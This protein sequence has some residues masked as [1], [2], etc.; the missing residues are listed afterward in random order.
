MAKLRCCEH[1]IQVGQPQ[2]QGMC[3]D[4]LQR[5][6]LDGGRQLQGTLQQQ[7]SALVKAQLQRRLSLHLSWA[8]ELIASSGEHPKDMS[9][10]LGMSM[11]GQIL[12]SF[13]SAFT[14]NM[15]G[16]VTG[17]RNHTWNIEAESAAWAGDPAPTPA[18][19]RTSSTG[20]SFSSC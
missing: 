6:Q 19:S 12:S 10:T 20:G 18:H 1:L 17:H 7:K 16:S 4:S 9:D 13:S 14:L 5:Q 11:P 15:S 8:A 3:A 2:Q